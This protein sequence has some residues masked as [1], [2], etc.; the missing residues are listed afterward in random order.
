MNLFKKKCE[1]CRKKIEKQKEIM[2]DVKTPGFVGTKE[3]AFC[4]S[5]HANSYEKELEEHLKNSKKCGGSCCG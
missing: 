1:Y 5:G 4:C 2:K 3:K